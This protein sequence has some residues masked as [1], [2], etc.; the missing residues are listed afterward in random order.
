MFLSSLLSVF[1]GAWMLAAVPFTVTVKS[2][3]Y[4]ARSDG[5]T[6][7][8]TQVVKKGSADKAGLKTG[9]TLLRISMPVRSF[10]SHTPLPLLNEADLLDA[11]TPQPGEYLELRVASKG[12]K[13]KGPG[14]VL[15]QSREP[16]PDNPF[17]VMPLSKEQLE[18]L[19]AQQMGLYFARLAQSTNEAMSGPVFRVSQKTT[20]YVAKERL[21]GVE[22]GGYTPLQVHPRLILELDCG[23]P[24]EKVEL[25]G[26]AGFQART[27]RPDAAN[28]TA[29]RFVVDP[30]LWTSE[31]VVQGCASART[32]HMRTLHGSLSCQGRPVMERDI[33]VTLTVSCDESIPQRVASARDL[34]SLEE[35][36]DILVGDTAPLNVA[37]YLD[38]LIPRPT[39][40]ALVELDEGGKAVQ[41]HATLELPQ[42]LQAQ[43]LQ[44]SLDT[45]RARTA[46]LA[47]KVRFADGGIWMSE[48][49][50]RLIRSKEQVEANAKLEPLAERLGEKFKDPCADLAATNAWLNEQ[51]D[52]IFA[53][54][55]ATQPYFFYSVAGTHG[56]VKVACPR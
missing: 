31:D 37:V 27:L 51:P 54:D 48:P 10:T 24:L 33:P 29:A 50:K 55:D 46:R 12:P 38:R 53:S 1:T 23:G 11:L 15:I 30:P 7:T 2:A 19:S 41:R 8:V 20:A 32:T 39:E 4:S 56:T 40:V 9:M 14:S 35:P 36:W 22:G 3:G 18:R 26:D 47:V 45:T 17:P 13:K 5:E 25:R 28:S 6:V 16:V 34:L 52:L 49:Q 21:E 42:E 44:V 43:K